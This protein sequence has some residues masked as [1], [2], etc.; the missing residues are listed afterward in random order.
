M[1]KSRMEALRRHRVQHIANMGVR[2]KV[3]QSRC[4]FS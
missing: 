3:M 4:G 2:S 1:G